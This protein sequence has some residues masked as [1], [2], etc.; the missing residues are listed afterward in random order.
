MEVLAVVVCMCNSKGGKGWAYL[1]VEILG[2]V[3]CRCNSEGARWVE[4]P[5][6]GRSWGGDVQVQ[7]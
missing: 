6:R 4:T 2:V 1:P 3:M 7:F 5:S